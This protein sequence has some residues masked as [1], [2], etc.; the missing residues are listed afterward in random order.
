MNVYS[1]L[2]IELFKLL[3]KRLSL[4]MMAILF[5][6]AFYTF[7]I[8]TDAPLLQMPESG[9]LD[10]TFATW[11]LLGMTGLFQVLFS[12]VT[13]SSF[14]SEIENGQIRSSVTRL[15][16]RKKIV[17]VKATALVIFSVLCYIAFMLFSIACYYALVIHT[18]YG[19][20]KWSG[21]AFDI[22][23]AVFAVGSIFP[24]VDVFVTAGIVYIFSLKYKSS[25]CFM[26]AMGT[27]AM[28]LIMQFFPWLKYLVPVYVKRLLDQGQISPASALA[29][30][31]PYIAASVGCMIFVAH[32]FE[33]MDLK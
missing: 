23:G 7:S 30:C 17:Y 29:L 27:S 28:F 33:R 5:V 9:A 6:P 4:A 18:P 11:S 22:L 19:N 32:K 31:I 25:I 2:K 16:N 21:E 26:L 14:S 15:C 13:V 12:L 20:G 3:K 10:F 24:L 8:M 1:M